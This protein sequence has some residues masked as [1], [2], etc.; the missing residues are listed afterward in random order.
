MLPNLGYHIRPG[1]LNCGGYA[2]HVTRSVKMADLV[3]V[4]EKS[5]KP[6][7]AYVVKESESASHFQ[8]VMRH[9]EN[10]IT[11]KNAPYSL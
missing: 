6:S 2:D 5:R 9:N 10:V 7:F 11:I 8:D 1:M 4:W 3:N